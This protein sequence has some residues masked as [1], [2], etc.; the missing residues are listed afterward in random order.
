MSSPEITFKTINS[1]W[2]DGVVFERTYKRIV[3]INYANEDLWQNNSRG[4]SAGSNHIYD[5]EY[6]EEISFSA[7]TLVRIELRHF[8]NSTSHQLGQWAASI[9]VIASLDMLAV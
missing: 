6:T 3:G 2:Y 8:L 9:T 5:P 7:D 1:D 4:K